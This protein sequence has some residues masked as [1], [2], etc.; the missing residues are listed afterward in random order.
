M[1]EPESL[2]CVM[3]AMPAMRGSRLSAAASCQSS[4]FGSTRKPKMHVLSDS[5]EVGRRAPTLATSSPLPSSAISRTLSRAHHQAC[6][7]RCTRCAAGG[8]S[9]TRA[10]RHAATSREQR[11]CCSSSGCH[12]SIIIR[13]LAAFDNPLTPHPGSA[14]SPQHD[15]R[16]ISSIR[17]L[18]HRRAAV[19]KKKSQC[20]RAFSPPQVYLRSKS[21]VAACT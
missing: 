6:K 11:I 10:A 4:V 20:I 8:D 15:P 18:R 9:E 2:M 5:M 7:P 3:P 13:F 21:R 1:R 12:A 19:A 16:R 14:S 17:R